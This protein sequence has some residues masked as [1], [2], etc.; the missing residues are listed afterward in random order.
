[1]SEKIN[2][3][4]SLHQ[5]LYLDKSKEE[6]ELKSY[7]LEI[8]KNFESHFTNQKVNLHANA[9]PSSLNIDKAVY[10]G[11]LITEL[12]TNSLKHA[13]EAVENK[14]IAINIY[15]EESTILVEYSDNGKGLKSGQAPSLVVLLMKQLRA[16]ILATD[17][18]GYSLK[19][20]FKK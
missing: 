9:E 8:F 12:I 18:L 19:F 17:Q 7:I 14:E 6:I 4:A 5:Q 10:L 15:A 3:I 13:F 2:S 20:K 1:M 11:L 16:S